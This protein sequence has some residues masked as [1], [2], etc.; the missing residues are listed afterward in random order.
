MLELITL[1]LTEDTVP[2]VEDVVAGP[3][4]ALFFILLIAATVFLCFSFVK[5]LRKTRAARDEGVFGDQPEAEDDTVAEPRSTD[6][7]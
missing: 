6:Q 4:G 2:K 5:Q 3:V 7:G 1:V